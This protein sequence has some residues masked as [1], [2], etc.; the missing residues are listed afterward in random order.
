MSKGSAKNAGL[1]WTDAEETDLFYE[2]SRG[3]KY[4]DIA[5]KH[6]RSLTEI[7]LRIK[8]IAYKLYQNKFTNNTGTYNNGVYYNHIT[9]YV[10]QSKLI[11]SNLST[12][13]NKYVSR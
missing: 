2:L 4:N 6:G 1:K 9:T 3:L 8:Q 12:N 7:D 10:K 13:V 5:Y 11:I